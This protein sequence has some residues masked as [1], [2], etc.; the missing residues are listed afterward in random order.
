MLHFVQRDNIRILHGF[1]AV[2]SAATLPLPFPSPA[3]V[4]EGRRRPGE[5]ISTEGFRPGLRYA[6]TLGL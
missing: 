5:G 1:L 2:G 6:A 3:R 4:G